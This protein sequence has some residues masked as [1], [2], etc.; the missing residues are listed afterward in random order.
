MRRSGGQEQK[1]RMRVADNQDTRLV[2]KSKE[3]KVVV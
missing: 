1:M 3:N 2:E